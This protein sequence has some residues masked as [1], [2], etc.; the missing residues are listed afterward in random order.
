MSILDISK[1]LMCEFWYNYI[2]PKNQE[3]AKLCFMV[4]DGFIIYIQTKDFYE[5]IANNIEKW[6]DTSNCDED[7]KKP[8]A[9]G[10]NKKVIGLFKDELGG[11]IIKEF[12]GPRAKTY[13]YLIDDN[14]EHKKAKGKKR[15]II[16]REFMFKN[17]RDC[18][19]NNAYYPKIETKIKKW[20]S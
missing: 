8:L 17:Y 1:T 15:C 14:T 9:I 13:A 20:L 7:D 4:T 10:K 18:L 5:D 16:K 12:A 3:K 11:K 6:F 2:K 19:L